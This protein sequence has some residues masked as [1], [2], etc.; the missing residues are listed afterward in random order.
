MLFT[1]SAATAARSFARRRRATSS[2]SFAPTTSG[3][4]T[5]ADSLLLQY[6]M[7][8]G[9]DKSQL[10]LHRAHAREVEGMIFIS[11]AQE[12]V[13]FDPVYA[14]IAPVAKPQGMARAKVAKI[15]D[16]DVASN[17]KL[18][19]ENNRECYHCTVNH[20][21]YIKANFDHYNADDTIPRVAE[22]L[23]AVTTRM[24]AKLAAQGMS[25]RD[26][27]GMTEFPDPDHGIWYAA[28]RTPLVEG[29]SAKRWMASRWLH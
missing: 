4:T 5:A 9:L 18:V 13:D 3:L 2:A 15:M 8:E 10:G 1:T 24:E 25:I 12:P 20:P 16:F 26:E 23:K 27:T 17:W 19:W 21:Q 29:L 14:T 28:N 11:L 7:Q 22:K 6:G